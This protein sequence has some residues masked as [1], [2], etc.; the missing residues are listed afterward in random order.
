MEIAMPATSLIRSLCQVGIVSHTPDALV[1]FYRDVLGLPLLF[2]ASGM[3]FLR[4]GTTS[5]MIGAAADTDDTHDVILYFEPTD[6]DAAEAAITAAG[7]AFDRPAMVV[8]RDGDNEHLLRPFRDPEGRHV[9]MLG[10][11]RAATA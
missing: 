7:I 8:E 4:A 6:W 2:E 3:S 9:Y 11:R 1:G 5:L 10:W